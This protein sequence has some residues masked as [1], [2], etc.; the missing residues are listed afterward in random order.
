MEYLQKQ[1]P[2]EFLQ[3]DCWDWLRAVCRKMLSCEDL[4]VVEAEE[5]EDLNSS[6]ASSNGNIDYSNK[7]SQ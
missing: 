2:F 1:W 4:E 6:T 5:R 7:Q 3:S